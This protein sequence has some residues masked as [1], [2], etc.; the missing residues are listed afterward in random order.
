MDTSKNV[1]VLLTQNNKIHNI[2]KSQY[3]HKYFIGFCLKKKEIYNII[4][5]LAILVT[6][7]FY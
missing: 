3:N 7:F 1:R 2:V 6:D 5:L 4:L